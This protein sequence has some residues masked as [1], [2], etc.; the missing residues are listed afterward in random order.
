VG[1]LGMNA[2]MGVVLAQRLRDLLY[3]Y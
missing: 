3:L 2:R 1:I